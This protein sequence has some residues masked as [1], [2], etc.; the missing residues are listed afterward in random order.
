MITSG[1][2]LYVNSTNFTEVSRTRTCV[3]NDSKIEIYDGW[4]EILRVI[5]LWTTVMTS[6]TP[7]CAT[8]WI[9][10]IFCWNPSKTTSDDNKGVRHN[11][12]CRNY[13]G[14]WKKIGI[15]DGWLEILS[16]IFLWTTVSNKMTSLAWRIW[17][18]NWRFYIRRHFIHQKDFLITL[19]N[20]WEK[21]KTYFNLMPKYL[22]RRSSINQQKKK[23]IV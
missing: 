13:F 16:V 4:L 7:P 2:I 22:L 21:L 15:Y 11:L 12:S 9:A 23:G 19:V 3:K 18:K 8:N 20:G 10:T 1:H 5:F 17:L 6:I 14:R